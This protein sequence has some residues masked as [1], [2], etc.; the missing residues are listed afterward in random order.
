MKK[1]YQRPR[2]M[3]HGSV[4]QVTLAMIGIMMNDGSGMFFMMRPGM[5]GS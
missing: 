2:L 1:T 3:R 5:D 4:E